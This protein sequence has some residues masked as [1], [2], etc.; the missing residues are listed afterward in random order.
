[1]KNFGS[2]WEYWKLPYV[3]KTNT[4]LAKSS[5]PSDSN[6]NLLSLLQSC[7]PIETENNSFWSHM[8]TWP[9]YFSLFVYL[10]FAMDFHCSHPKYMVTDMETDIHGLKYILQCLMGK[11][12]RIVSF[13]VNVITFRLVCFRSL[14]MQPRSLVLGCEC[15]KQIYQLLHLWDNTSNS[16]SLICSI[17]RNCWCTMHCIVQYTVYI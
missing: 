15:E 8:G 9:V 4:G 13:L 7:F 2:N 1:M 12:K 17:Y 14:G 10:I 11:I 16:Y 5:T 6:M 3:S